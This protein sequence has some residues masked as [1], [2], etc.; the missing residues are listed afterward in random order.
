[1][2]AC[3]IS[4]FCCADSCELTLLPLC[5]TCASR[6]DSLVSCHDCYFFKDPASNVCESLLH[7][8]HIYLRGYKMVQMFSVF[9]VLNMM[10]HGVIRVHQGAVVDVL[11]STLIN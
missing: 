6:T 10:Q 9:L 4:L 2:S 11:M 1:M 8:A 5:N 3:Q 7:L